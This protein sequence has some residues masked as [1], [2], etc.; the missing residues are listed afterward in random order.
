[1]RP[2]GTHTPPVASKMMENWPSTADFSSRMRFWDYSPISNDTDSRR[3]AFRHY[4]RANSTLD[5]LKSLF[6]SLQTIRFGNNE[7]WIF[8]RRML[9]HCLFIYLLV[10][11]WSYTTNTLSNHIE[12]SKESH[13]GPGIVRIGQYLTSSRPCSLYYFDYQE[14][15]ERERESDL[16]TE[17]IA[18]NCRLATKDDDD[19]WQTKTK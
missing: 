11:R 17:L 9:W 13:F 14:R 5:L 19:C 10:S 18:S 12:V 1:M 7:F 8:T 3:S 16:T 6:Y 15:G 4:N 2:I